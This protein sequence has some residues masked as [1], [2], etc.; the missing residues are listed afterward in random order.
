MQQSTSPT[1]SEELRRQAEKK[2]QQIRKGTYITFGEVAALAINGIM[3]FLFIRSSDNVRKQY[4]E[5]IDRINQQNPETMQP[6]C[7]QGAKE[8][9]AALDPLLF[10][11][12]DIL[13]T[14]TI[15]T[16]KNR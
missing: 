13:K 5:E 9:C 6:L 1:H 10:R 2:S 8:L 12:N 3:A 7:E 4:R 15:E 14:G 11:Y 16:A